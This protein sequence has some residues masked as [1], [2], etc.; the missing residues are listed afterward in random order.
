[1]NHLSLA[2][3]IAADEFDMCD[4]ELQSMFPDAGSG[5]PV[6]VRYICTR[7]DFTGPEAFGPVAAL[8]DVREQAEALFVGG[9]SCQAGCCG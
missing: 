1:M 8:G 2:I 9:V 4:R 3:D 5:D 6:F 7:C